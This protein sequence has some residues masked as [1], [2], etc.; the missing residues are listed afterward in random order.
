MPS[1]LSK[2]FGGR[3]KDD[4]QHLASPT[5]PAAGRGRV[6]S[7]LD[8]KYEAVSPVSPS[9]PGLPSPTPSKDK[10]EKEKEKDKDG[11]VFPALFKS[12]ARP[13]SPTRTS[14]GGSGA[15]SPKQQQAPHLSLN[16]PGAARTL[17]TVFEADPAAQV[18]LSDNELA[19]RRLA[20]PEALAL[21]KACGEYISERGASIY[22]FVSLSILP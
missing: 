2:V 7:L 4:H 3:K 8:G 12:R 22:Q 13:M 1:F 19:E 18:V 6:P 10:E 20:P 9:A 11:G 16:L 14:S 17:G 21:V 15:S 5:S